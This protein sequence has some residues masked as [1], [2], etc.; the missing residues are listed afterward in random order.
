[1]S[2]KLTDEE[3]IIYGTVM[4]EINSLKRECSV[5]DDIE[6][7]VIALIKLGLLHKKR[8]SKK[9]SPLNDSS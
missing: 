6:I 4:G 1:M 8:R 9:Q 5:E 7:L 3:D 2:L